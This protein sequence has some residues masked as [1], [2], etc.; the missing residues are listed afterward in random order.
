MGITAKHSSGVDITPGFMFYF[1]RDSLSRG[2]GA[3]CVPVAGAWTV[4]N[5]I[6]V[7]NEY[8]GYFEYVMLGPGPTLQQRQIHWFVCVHDPKV[9]A[10]P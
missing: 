2:I 1:A 8:G 3:L 10:C 7:E 9:N 4:V 6:W 5:R